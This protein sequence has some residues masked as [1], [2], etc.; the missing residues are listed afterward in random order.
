M[1][2]EK[3]IT[4]ETVDDD[5]YDGKEYKK[6][7]DTDGLYYNVKQG[8]GGILKAKWDL[9]KPGASIKLILGIFKN[10]PFV[11]D[12]E[13]VSIAVPQQGKARPSETTTSIERQVAFKGAI[14]LLT[15]Q[16]IKLEHPFADAAIKW[17][18]IRL[19]GEGNIVAVMEVEEIK[20]TKSESE[21]LVNPVIA[22]A[23]KLGAQVVET[24]PVAPSEVKPRP[25]F[26]NVGE[27]LMYYFKTYKLTRS[28]VLNLLKVENPTDI[29]DP[30]AAANELDV[31]I[32]LKP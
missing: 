13:S 29:K 20:A 4:I 27:L 18:Q 24:E 1:A 7:M 12:I 8:R 31:F 14:E 15:A 23:V 22:E 10:K 28:M 21:V 25:A 9:L 17:G 5:E 16:I 32:N 30:E 11:H 26:K 3:I 6:V 2:T 19:I